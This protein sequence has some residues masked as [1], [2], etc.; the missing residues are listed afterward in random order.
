MG[1]HPVVVGWYQT[2]CQTD[3]TGAHRSTLAQPITGSSRR[4][5]LISAWHVEAIWSFWS[6]SRQSAGRLWALAVASYRAGCLFAS[7]DG[8]TGHSRLAALP[9][10]MDPRR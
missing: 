9:G 4:S 8:G 10:L 1:L 7:Y 3:F 2:R 6:F 5:P